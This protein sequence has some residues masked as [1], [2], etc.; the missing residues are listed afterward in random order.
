MPKAI[1]KTFILLVFTLFSNLII[2]AQN[3]PYRFN[4]KTWVNVLFVGEPNMIDLP[5]IESIK[6]RIK[7]KIIDYKFAEIRSVTQEN[8][9]VFVPVKFANE[10]K[11]RFYLKSDGNLIDSIDNVYKI[12]ELPLPKLNINEITEGNN[13]DREKIQELK[14]LEITKIES[15][16][17][18][19]DFQIDS[20]DVT[21]VGRRIFPQRVRL[22]GLCRDEGG[23]LLNFI[24]KMDGGDI[25]QFHRIKVK[26]KKG[27]HFF[28]NNYSFTIKENNIERQKRI[29]DSIFNAR[30]KKISFNQ[31]NKNL[32]LNSKSL[33]KNLIQ[34]LTQSLFE[35]YYFKLDLEKYEIVNTEFNLYKFDLNKELKNTHNG[36][37]Y[38][39]TAVRQLKPGI[40]NQKKDFD[41]LDD[42]NYQEIIYH[43]LREIDSL[44]I[45][46]K[47][48]KI[49]NKNEVYLIAFYKNRKI[50]IPIREFAKL[51]IIFPEILA[52]YLTYK[53]IIKATDK[54][55]Y[56]FDKSKMTDSSMMTEYYLSND[57]LNLIQG[58]GDFQLQKLYARILTGMDIE[59][60]I[61][62]NDI[63]S[64]EFELTLD[65]DKL[66]DWEKGALRNT[67]H[68]PIWFFGDSVSC[69][70]K[71]KGY[72]NDLIFELLKNDENSASN[73]SNT[74]K[75]IN[76]LKLNWIRGLDV[77][78]H[79]GS[80]LEVELF[81]MI[82]VDRLDNSLEYFSEDYSLNFTSLPKIYNNLN[83][84]QKLLLSEISQFNYLDLKIFQK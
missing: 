20:F 63:S 4:L 8:I 1:H 50:A 65:W 19:L 70:P 51:K 43:V 47:F 68:K 61:L 22:P 39:E 45:E 71:L 31:F 54:I 18:K 55:Y 42:N 67:T 64:G 24:Q 52:D 77:I 48:N 26:S 29:Q 36:F 79:V 13:L 25:I 27:Y 32:R 35:E 37:C 12:I 10:M 23:F 58:A 3:T 16:Y 41:E 21:I 44:T 17:K 83:S 56:C 80:N 34:Y 60:A 72:G 84:L 82:K 5:Q 38:G 57:L 66:I 76:E 81:L 30:Y 59:K 14:C 40:D 62:S 15:E 6:P 7:F 46:E 28:A 33:N 53:K 9:S 73:N 69:V 11:I 78:S 49:N 74:N 75:Q 2:N